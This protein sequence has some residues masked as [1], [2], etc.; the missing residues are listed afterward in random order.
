[1]K[2][3]PFTL[4]VIHEAL[5]SVVA[6]M[7]VTL[8]RT[9]FSSIIYEGQ[10]F[11]CALADPRGRLACQS[12]EDFPAHV[13]PLNM[14]VPQAVAKYGD[15]IHPGDLI[16][17]NDPFTSGT[18]LNDVALIAPIFWRNKLIMFACSRA[19]WGDV[20]GMTPGSI[21]GQTADI[22]QEGVRIPI[23][24]LHDRGRPNEA[25]YDLLFGNVRQ[26]GDRRGDLMSQM[27]AAKSGSD[28]I[29]KLVERFGHQTLSQC[30]DRILDRSETRMRQRIARLKKGTY[31]F[32]DYLDSDGHSDT[33]IPI[34]V[35]VTVTDGAVDVDFEGSAPQRPGPTNASLAVTSTAVFVAMK[36]LLDPEG[37]INEGAFRPF[38]LHVPKG[39]LLDAV[40]PAP[41]GGFVEVLRRVE[42][43][44]MGAM[45][46]CVPEDVA[47]DTKGCAN[48]LYI[49][50]LAGNAVRS[51]HY[52]Y[53]SGGT[54]GFNG[55]DGSNALREWDTGDF[56]SV[57][58]AEIVEREHA[59]LVEEYALRVDSGGAGRWRGGLGMRRVIRIDGER[60]NLSILS[61]RNV[62][63][64]FGVN[65]GHSAQPNSFNVLRDGIV[66]AP[67]QLPGKVSGFPL[68]AG[69]RV[70]ALSAG[71]GGFGDPGERSVDSVLRDL[72]YGYISE[73]AAATLYD[74]IGRR[75]VAGRHGGHL[76]SGR[77]RLWRDPSP[78][79]L[80]AIVLSA[81][82][83]AEI[84]IENGQIV[85]LVPSF[86]APS[87]GIVRIRDDIPARGEIWISPQMATVLGCA[88]G[89]LLSIRTFDHGS[90]DP[91]RGWIAASRNLAGA[92]E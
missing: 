76:T 43:L 44:L 90:H 20:G 48:H 81:E 22:Y 89:E 88:E 83:A 45:S 56:S 15:D 4:E 91:S 42:S 75:R 52:E 24:K 50:H 1:M 92:A 80:E 28:R 18:H 61:D 69:D 66:I 12:R 73:Q 68:R 17:T 31:R 33:P 9:A 35:K 74:V 36:A 47:G 58:S 87:R 77:C 59:C 67:S 6:E 64:P 14:Q 63:P 16:L 26:S 7:R 54:G 21:S 62:I 39:S 10:D 72:A 78:A 46:R 82:T 30:I 23:L 27:S 71:G 8:L 19:H 25:V 86:G 2:I 41:M 57:H 5:I 60:A 34:C 65:G 38:R 13:G 32:K 85:E 49:S 84:G 70:I 79:G 55:G 11:S 3:D 37:P 29:L 40:H 53:P 51:I